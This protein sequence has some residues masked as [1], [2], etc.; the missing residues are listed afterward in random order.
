MIQ[1]IQSLYFLFA[2]IL[3]FV[4]YLFPLVNYSGE[5]LNLQLFVCHIEGDESY[6]EMLNLIPLT[7]LPILSVLVSLLSIFSFKNRSLQIKLG[8]LNMAIMLVVLIIGSIYFI[9]LNQIVSATGVPGF[10]SILPVLIIILTYMATKAVKKDD[11]LV[12]SADRIR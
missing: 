3:A 6:K 7:F 2:A 11:N 12:K 10:S 1:R 5:S 8:K 9:K 4:M